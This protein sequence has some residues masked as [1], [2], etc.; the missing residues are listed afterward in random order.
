[1]PILSKKSQD[2]LK[3][4]KFIKLKRQYNAKIMFCDVP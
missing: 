4:L 3:S 1:M 2:F